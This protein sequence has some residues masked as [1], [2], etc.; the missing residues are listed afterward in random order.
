MTATAPESEMV[1]VTDVKAYMA[2]KVNP[3]LSELVRDLALNQPEDVLL[4]LR[5][6]AERRIGAEFAGEAET[7]P[8]CCMSGFEADY[9]QVCAADA[10][11]ALATH[12]LAM[13][14]LD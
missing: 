3:I 10:E 13:R 1:D 11:P 8:L 2:T 14:F 7:R 9:K 5:D 12:R 6:F 4:F